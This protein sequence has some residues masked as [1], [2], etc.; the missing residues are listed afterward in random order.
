MNIQFPFD[1]VTVSAENGQIVV[2]HTHDEHDSAGENRYDSEN[3][4][5]VLKLLRQSYR[6]AK[7]QT[8]YMKRLEKKAKKESG[9]QD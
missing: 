8:R 9:N 4:G 6:D 1:L 2:L 7:R 3:F 5:E